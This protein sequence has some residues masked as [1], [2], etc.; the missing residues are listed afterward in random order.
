MK[1]IHLT[2]IFI[3]FSMMTFAQN[4]KPYKIDDSVQVS[5]P[6]GFERKD[7]LGQTLI[8]AKSSFGN[9]LITVSPDNP[10]TTPDIEKETHL[11]KYYDDFVTRIKESSKDGSILNEKDTLMGKLHVRDLTLA[12]DSG[13]GKQL[14]NIRIL[15]ENSSTY[16]FQFLYQEIH[17]EYADPES[18]T[19]FNSIKIPPDAAIQT[20]FTNPE[21]TTGKTPTENNTLYIGI[22]IALLILIILFFILKKPKRD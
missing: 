12:V 14:R 20:Q 6:T 4:W 22:G 5:L 10:K 13:S 21:N 16:T 3:L 18:S 7:T 19:F 11:Q 15:H 8:N 9:V 2:C 1:K 17:K